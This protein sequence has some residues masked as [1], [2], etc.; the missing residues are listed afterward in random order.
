MGFLLSGNGIAGGWAIQLEGIPG[1]CV[2]QAVAAP[3]LIVPAGDA[4]EP[5]PARIAKTLTVGSTNT[6]L[7]LAGSITATRQS[8]I[9]SVATRLGVCSASTSIQ[10]CRSTANSAPTV[11]T[12]AVVPQ[13]PS[14]V[15]GQII[16]VT[17]VLSFS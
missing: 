3:C 15:Q 12:R 10:V 2:S 13:P 5:D 14:V 9:N 4:L 17:V 1:P 8:Q 7:I 6:G 16:Q 11:M